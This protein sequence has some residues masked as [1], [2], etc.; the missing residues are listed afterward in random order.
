MPG[1][2][3]NTQGSRGGGAEWQQCETVLAFNASTSCRPRR[4][5][6]DEAEQEECLG[7]HIIQQ[8]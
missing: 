4:G 8:G 6:E 2:A 1:Q 7:K 5:F 3:Y